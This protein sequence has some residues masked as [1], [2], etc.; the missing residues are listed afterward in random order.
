M[1]LG[2]I[3]S[4]VD[5]NEVTEGSW[6]YFSNDLAHMKQALKNHKINA[7]T[8]YDRLD[9]VLPEHEPRRFSSADSRLLF[10]IFCPMRDGF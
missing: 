7:Y 6:G 9:K 1:E 2:K 5:A 8:Y 3:Y 4:C 10:S